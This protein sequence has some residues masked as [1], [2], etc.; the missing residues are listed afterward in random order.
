MW[1]RSSLFRSM[2]FR[3]V[4][5]LFDKWLSILPNS[6]IFC[7]SYKELFHILFASPN[8]CFLLTNIEFHSQVKYLGEDGTNAPL[9]GA[10]A[11]C[12]PWDILVSIFV[13]V[14][15]PNFWAIFDLQFSILEGGSC[16]YSS[17]SYNP[18]TLLSVRFYRTKTQ[19]LLLLP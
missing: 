9:V 3:N 4:L 19:I 16:L 6:Y 11:I 13:S 7:F 17:F 1:F 12:C 14:I 18:S 5:V 8:I 15:Q 2:H 10:A